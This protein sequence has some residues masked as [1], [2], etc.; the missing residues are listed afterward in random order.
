MIIN[1]IDSIERARRK[2]NCYT[3]G[4]EINKND[5][6][7]VIIT[8]FKQMWKRYICKKC[9]LKEIELDIKNCKKEI[10]RL[11]QIKYEL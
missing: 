9:C 11:E 1:T 10:K 3:C 4:T 8:S 5:L 7:A 6:R 2:C